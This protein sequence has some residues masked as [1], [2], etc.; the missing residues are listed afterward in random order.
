MFKKFIIRGL[1]ALSLL[2][3]FGMCISYGT[4]LIIK[5]KNLIVT[6]IPILQS[7]YKIEE[8][9]SDINFIKQELAKCSHEVERILDIVYSMNKQRAIAESY[10]RTLLLLANIE[11]SVINNRMANITTDVV[12]LVNISSID[13]NLREI[14][15]EI[16]DVENVYG[17]KYFEQTFSEIVH[18]V[19]IQY[20]SDPK[21]GKVM[22]ALKRYFARSFVY[23]TP[24]GNEV[25]RTLYYARIQ[26]QSGD[27]KGFYNSMQ[28]LH[29]QTEKMEG[30][31]K[32]VAGYNQVMSTVERARKYI[33]HLVVENKVD[34]DKKAS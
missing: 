23:L 14:V 26:L 3:V 15:K 19:I 8:N 18:H 30:F 29:L 10:S 20:Y 21:D 27:M 28:S 24:S 13:F 2:V 6:Q 31:I 25:N 1:I 12:A 5:K 32:R 7:E 33:E 34:L 17:Y 16:D 4:Y 22:G 9:A 11:N